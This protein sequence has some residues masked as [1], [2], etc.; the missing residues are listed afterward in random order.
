MRIPIYPCDLI[1]KT[2]GLLK[3]AST[4]QKNWPG[5]SPI[6]IFQAKSIV[7]QGLG[8]KSLQELK[9][10]SLNSM[11][12]EYEHPEKELMPDFNTPI[13][14]I[15][16]PQSLS[17][18]EPSAILNLIELLPL[19]KLFIFGGAPSP[20]TNKHRTRPPV[21][22]R[23]NHA[24]R[25]LTTDELH[26][27]SLAA[28]SSSNER[29]VVMHELLRLGCKAYEVAGARF[30]HSGLIQVPVKKFDS[31]QVTLPETATDM[32]L[33]MIKEAGIYPDSYLFPSSS[34][35]NHIRSGKVTRVFHSW[36]VKCGLN[37]LGITLHI[38]R[39]SV[40]A[41]RFYETASH[42]AVNRPIHS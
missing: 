24:S 11:P 29:D 25:V 28:L 4:L 42:L 10:L 9:S 20:V 33:R 36:L 26:S 2:G 21:V 12:S 1:S 18:S 19:H 23:N 15:L 38:F 39:R 27:I 30:S 35:D 6:S 31:V 16:K 37:Q 3:I 8:Y 32:L 13:S 14:A 34:G 17:N 7:A 22:R 41:H 5:R 40:E